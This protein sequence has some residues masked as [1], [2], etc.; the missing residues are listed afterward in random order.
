MNFRGIVLIKQGNK[1]RVEPCHRTKPSFG[2]KDEKASS[3]CFGVIK[4]HLM[5]QNTKRHFSNRSHLGICA[6]KL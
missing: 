5:L 4:V 2:Q 3:A 1:K 6:I